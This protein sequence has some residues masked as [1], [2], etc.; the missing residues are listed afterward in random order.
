V[1]RRPPV[2]YERDFVAE[3]NRQSAGSC[4]VRYYGDDKMFPYVL[5]TILIQG[6][7]IY[8]IHGN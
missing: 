7:L 1:R 2:F 3:Y 8:N 6:E 5:T 4:V